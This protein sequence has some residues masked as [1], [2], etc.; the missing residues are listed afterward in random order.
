MSAQAFAAV[1]ARVLFWIIGVPCGIWLTF[2]TIAW[3]TDL[4]DGRL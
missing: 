3:L 2:K 4:F 1:A